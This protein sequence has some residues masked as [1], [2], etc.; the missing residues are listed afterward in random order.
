MGWMYRLANAGGENNRSPGKGPARVR[1]R[2][3]TLFPL[4]LKHAWTVQDSGSIAMRCVVLL[5]RYV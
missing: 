4:H 5:N 3:T 1:A 2:A